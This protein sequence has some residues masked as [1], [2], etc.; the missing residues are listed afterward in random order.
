M[1]AVLIYE[2]YGLMLPSLDDACALVGRTLGL[3]LFPHE[4]GYKGGDYFRA[5]RANESFV[6]QRNFNEIEQAWTEPA[7]QEFPLLLYVNKE[8]PK[9]NY[10]AL[11]ESTGHA[12]WIWRRTVP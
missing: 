12:S 2:L 8:T 10:R 7:H 5:Q 9:N 3:Q 11:L 6:L 1:K 4:S